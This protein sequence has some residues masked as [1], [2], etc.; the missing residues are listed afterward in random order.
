M[1]SANSPTPSTPCSP[2]SKQ[3][4]AEQQR[5]AANA[6]HELRTPLA[7]TQTLLDVA[8]ND[9]DRGPNELVDRLD[10]V[11][12]RAIDLT[13]AL[14]LLSR[15]DQQSFTRTRRPIPHRGRGHRDAP[16]LRR[17]HGV[18]IETSGDVTITIGSRLSSCCSWRRTSC[19]T[20]SSTI[21]RTRAPCGSPPALT[22]RPWCSRSRT[23]ERAHPAAG[24]HARRAIS[25]RHRTNTHRPRRCRPRPGHRQEHHQSTRRE[26]HPH[27]SLC[28]WAL[29]NRAAARL[30]ATEHWPIKRQPA[31]QFRRAAS[32]RDR[33]LTDA[34]KSDG[35]IPSH[36]PR[37][38]G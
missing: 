29:C 15:V 37:Y 3:H 19:T 6:S 8:R 35:H 26:P 36:C 12:T 13:E 33:H 7:I 34:P 30:D 24:L 9:P 5:F 17:R 10:A 14:L 32:P 4:I 28:W 18:T 1:S 31:T 20:R 2:N 11:N 38:A 22:P 16:P 21:C 27:P 25:A 23:P